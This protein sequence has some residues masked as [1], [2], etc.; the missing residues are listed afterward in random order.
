MSCINFY[1]LYIQNVQYGFRINQLNLA[2]LRTHKH[3]DCLMGSNVSFGLH[4]PHG[5]VF[6]AALIA[7]VKNNQGAHRIAIV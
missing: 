2:H 7:H 4:D 3:K 1:K 5:Y 6:Q